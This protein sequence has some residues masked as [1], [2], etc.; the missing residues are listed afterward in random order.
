MVALDH[1][2]EFFFGI[3][4]IDIKLIHQPFQQHK[5]LLPASGN[6]SDPIA[7]KKRCQHLGFPVLRRDR[8]SERCQ[9]IGGEDSSTQFL[10]LVSVELVE[11]GIALG[12]ALSLVRWWETVGSLRCRSAASSSTLHSF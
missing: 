6:I 5:S 11:V 8:R 12:S 7:I 4:P 1:R 9:L 2:I 10:Q 3:V